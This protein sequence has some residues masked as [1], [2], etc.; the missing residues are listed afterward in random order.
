MQSKIR[1]IR[2]VKAALLGVMAFVL[3]LL[4]ISLPIFPSFLK[5][6]FSLLFP[7]LG[8][9]AL[10]PM[11]GVLIELVKNFLHFITIGIGSTAGVGDLA[12]F[13]VGGALVLTAGGIYARKKTRGTAILGL[14]CG[15]LAMTVTGAV[16]NAFITVPFYATAFFAEAGGMDAIIRMCA[17]I[18][19][20]IHDRF[21]VILFTFCPF[22][23]LKGVVLTVVTIPVYK[24]VSPLL[25]A[26]SF[27]NSGHNRKPK[28]HRT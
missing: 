11:A 24:Y 1:T 15:V 17:A 20:A 5:L 28:E 12:N 10:G 7:L 19:P 8:A 2:F 13:L 23:L 9:F 6:D 22:N 18:I 3:E 27:Y 4:E 21:T 26:E 25:K 14:V 16:V